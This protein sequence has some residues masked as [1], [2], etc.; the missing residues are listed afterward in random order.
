MIQVT[1]SKTHVRITL[2]LPHDDVGAIAML[3]QY[4]EMLAVILRVA[5]QWCQ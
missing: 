3:A 5:G 1:G 4:G 2:A